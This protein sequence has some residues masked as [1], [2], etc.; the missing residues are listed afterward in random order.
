[1]NLVTC[2]LSLLRRY[3]KEKVNMYAAYRCTMCPVLL[4]AMKQTQDG[5][6]CHLAC[7]QWM[8]EVG[9]GASSTLA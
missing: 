9:S 6:W 2:F 4:G 8:P 3:V 7:A 1:M 5:R